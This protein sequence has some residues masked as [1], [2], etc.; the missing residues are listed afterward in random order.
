MKTAAN[1]GSA[2]EGDGFSSQV[3]SGGTPANH[4]RGSSLWKL[5][6]FV[7]LNIFVF[8]LGILLL[9]RYVVH[10]NAGESQSNTFLPTVLFIKG[11]ES[12]DSLGAM[13]PAIHLLER[14]RK[15]LVYESILFQ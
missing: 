15:A 12:T 10:A 2:L 13:L 3:S 8:N 4:L 9:D 6:V 14:D 5:P 11:F 7:L 1:G